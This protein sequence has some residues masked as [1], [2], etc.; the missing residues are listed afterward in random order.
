MHYTRALSIADLADIA[1]DRLPPSL[2]GYVSGG[3]EDQSSLV[4]NRLAYDRWRFVT[5]SLVDVSQ[6]SQAVEIFGTRYD[7]PLGIAPMGV[8]GLCAFEGDLALARAAAR[9]KAPFVLSGASTVPLERVMQAA[10][11]TWYQAY[12]PAQQEVI[13]PLLDR[14]RAAQV[15]VLVVTVDVPIA[16]TRENEL[17]NDFRLPLK[18]TPRLL[19]GGAMRPRWLLQTFAQ[20]LL[21]GGVPRFE[22]FTATRG[23]RIIDAPTVD[24]RAG[25]A[26]MRWETI[27]WIRE[28]WAGKLVIK[29][30]LRRDDARQAEA[31]GCD[32]VIVSNHGGRQLDGAVAT[33]D[34]L[35]AIV[36][37]APGLTVMLDGGVRRGT[38][39][40]KAMALGAA[41]VFV[42]R[43]AM[44]GLAAG[45][46][47][48]AVR[49]LELLRKEIDVDLALL[50]CPDVAGLGPKYLVR[51]G[52]LPGM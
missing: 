41:C 27:A 32:G 44:Y 7:M 51:E 39:V 34:A 9:M 46:E 45:G 23:A 30:L 49:A 21:R 5:H 17:R 10:P 25:R 1:R 3:S 24:H 48:G 15:E 20:T 52:D 33:L 37:A 29:G 11:G 4:S 50:G 35:P 13:A 36:A 22:N 43:P 26:S 42:G 8:T 6:R 47:D 31:L 16:S 2:Y 28:Q 18:L 38:D 14:L 12:I 40:L 19:A